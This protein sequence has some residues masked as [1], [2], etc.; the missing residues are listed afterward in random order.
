MWLRI[1]GLLLI[2]LALALSLT[3]APDLPVESLVARW[4]PPP[5]EFIDLRGQIVHLRDEGPRSDRE[6]IVLL[7]GTSSSLHTWEGWVKALKTERRVVTLD[8]PGFGLTGPFTGSYAADDYRGDTLARFV[9]DVLDHLQLQRVVIG[10]NSLGGE[11]AW[12]VASLAP[13]RVSKL[14][15]VD[16]S[17]LP[18]QPESIPLGFRIARIPILNRAGEYW[19][20]KSLI[21]QGLRNTY[22]DPARVSSTL[23]DRYY[24][25]TLREGNRRALGLRVQQLSM[26][27]D[28]ARVDALKLPTLI[29]WGG[30]DRLVPPSVA[31]DFQRRIAGSQL[32]LYPELGHLPHEEDP[33]QT[34]TALRGF[35][36]A[37]P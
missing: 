21:A 26:G 35:L 6:P 25:L 27:E 11:I 32:V 30:R 20:P 17:G 22:G 3:R 33:G 14:V 4:A 18:F 8:M 28:A 1:L 37:P 19:L 31:Q 5:S 29:L 9:I 36:S 16:A 15:L 10:G 13:E 2:L 7:H 34:L 12:R 23:I 24:E